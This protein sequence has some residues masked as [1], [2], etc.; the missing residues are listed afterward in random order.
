MLVFSLTTDSRFKQFYEENIERKILTQKT[1]IE[2]DVL[3][4]TTAQKRHQKRIRK[5]KMK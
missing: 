4:A 1:D 2:L 5:L 3:I